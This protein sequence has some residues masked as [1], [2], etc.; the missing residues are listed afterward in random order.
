VIQEPRDLTVSRIAAVADGA[1]A[2]VVIGEGSPAQGV[3]PG[4]YCR[5]YD[6]RAW[7]A[8]RLITEAARDLDVTA[9][10]ARPEPTALVSVVSWSQTPP[11]VLPKKHV[12]WTPR[13]FWLTANGI[14]EAADL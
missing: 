9:V 2:H 3:P 5:W 11:G 4:A 7:S 10:H 13:F 12:A 1:V 6:G 14:E 8:W